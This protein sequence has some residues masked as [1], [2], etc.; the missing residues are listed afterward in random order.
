VNADRDLLADGGRGIQAIQIIQRDDARPAELKDDVQG[1][2]PVARGL[3]LRGDRSEQD[4]DVT[5]DPGRRL[6]V[7]RGRLVDAVGRNSVLRLNVPP[8]T[9]GLLPDPDVAVLGQF[10]AAVAALYD[11]NVAAGRPATADSV[12]AGAAAYAAASAFD[13]KL[14]TY[15]AAAEGARSAR[16]EV[17]L[18]SARSFDLINLREPIALGERTTQY[19]V[20]ARVNGTWTT[21]ATGTSIGERKLFRVDPVSADAVALVI[22]AARGA[23][24]VAEF[25]LYDTAPP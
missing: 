8:T 2:K 22:A 24:A 10:G 11:A 16:L 9:A 4:A 23:P 18:D 3:A 14:D 20:D 7:E 15:W 21:I 1:L 17:A 19:H 25:G 13:G 12:F 5:A 6:L